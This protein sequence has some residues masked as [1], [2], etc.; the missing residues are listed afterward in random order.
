[1]YNSINSYNPKGE[2][3]KF[4]QLGEELNEL[5][6]RTFIKVY[7]YLRKLCR[8]SFDWL[9]IH[10]KGKSFEWPELGATLRHPQMIHPYTHIANKK[11]E[12]MLNDIDIVCYSLF[13]TFRSSRVDF[14]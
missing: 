12:L 5:C 7:K 9:T 10:E 1:M 4:V 13:G 8:I 2:I 3:C 14:I 11:C 6:Y